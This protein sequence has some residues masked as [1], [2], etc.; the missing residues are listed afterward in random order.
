M[1]IAD[2]MYVH[3]HVCKHVW[4]HE[5]IHFFCLTPVC[6]ACH[7]ISDRFLEETFSDPLFIHHLGTEDDSQSKNYALTF[8][9]VLIAWEQ[10]ENK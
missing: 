5:E 4:L 1:Y 6:S 10:V 8:L 9:L 2:C 7:P 3:K